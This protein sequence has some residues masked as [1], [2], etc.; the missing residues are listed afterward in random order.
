MVLMALLK[1]FESTRACIKMFVITFTVKA[2]P[3]WKQGNIEIK[4]NHAMVQKQMFADVKSV[5]FLR[6][7]RFT[8]HFDWLLLTIRTAKKTKY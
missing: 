5:N 2:C 4:L 8:E 1:S 6:T 3:W 7:L